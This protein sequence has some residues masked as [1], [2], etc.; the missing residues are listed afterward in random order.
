LNKYLKCNV[1]R[2]AVRYVIYIYIYIRL[3]IYIYIYIYVVS[4]LRVKKKQE[5]LS[6]QLFP[7]YPEDSSNIGYN[8]R[9]VHKIK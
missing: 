1:W 6:G 8:L 9:A 5:V 7:T 4:R 3:Y 2:L